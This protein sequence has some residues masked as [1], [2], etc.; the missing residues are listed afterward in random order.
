MW[1]FRA[2][3][4]KE[5][6]ELLTVHSYKHLHKTETVTGKKRNLRKVYTQTLSE[7]ADS[8]FFLLDVCVSRPY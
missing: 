5:H 1:T 8:V 2:Q 6:V 7:L 3:K 4:D